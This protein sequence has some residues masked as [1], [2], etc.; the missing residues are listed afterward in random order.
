MLSAGDRTAARTLWQQI[1]ASDQPWMR[2]TAERSLQQLQALDQIDELQALV[3]RAAIPAGM[4]V[5]W[6]DLVRRRLLRG[7]PLDP[8]GVP[9]QLE[10]D[11]SRVTLSPASPLS[12]LPDLSSRFR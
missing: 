5:T 2:R 4:R 9:Y 8:G 12:P 7:I 1:M 11:T 10:A 3:N 6:A